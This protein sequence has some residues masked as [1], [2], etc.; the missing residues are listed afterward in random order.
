MKFGRDIR[1]S[2]SKLVNC[3]QLQVT[4]YVTLKLELSRA[5]T[6]HTL[7]VHPAIVRVL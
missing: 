2:S 6:P 3:F 5:H 1:K 7:H 4:G